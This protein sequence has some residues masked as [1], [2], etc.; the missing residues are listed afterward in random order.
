MAARRFRPSLAAAL[1]TLVVAAVCLQA[2]FW[3]LDRG[4]SK[5]RV[6]AQASERAE[7]G[8]LTLTQ[9][10]AEA[11]PGNFPVRVRG[12]IDN[13]HPILLDNRTLNGVAGYHLLSPLH[14]DTGHWVLVNRGWLPR[15]RDRNQLPDI[16][17]IEGAVTVIGQ[18]YVYSPLTLVLAEDD[19]SAATWPLRVQKV[20]MEAIAPLLGVEL[21]PFEIRV[22][23]EA[24]L[25]TAG[26]LPRVWHDAVMGPERH[27]AYALQW[28]GLAVTVVI[29]FLVVSFRRRPT[30]NSL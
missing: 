9:M 16:P 18:T 3:Q 6:L 24:E 4:R 20:E 27:Q 17:V 12:T 10:L 1:A 23:P 22:H 7:Q 14:S 8:P 2:A 26:E 30:K 13:D 29:F 11:E 19:L 25:E 28:F 5:A 21:A 15:G